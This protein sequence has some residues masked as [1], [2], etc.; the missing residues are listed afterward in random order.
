MPY[1]YSDEPVKEAPRAP[2]IKIPEKPKP[3]RTVSILFLLLTIVTIV[4]LYLLA[5]AQTGICAEPIA[6]AVNASMAS[7]PNVNST[8]TFND[9]Y[10]KGKLE[11]RNATL[12]EGYTKCI[13]ETQNTTLVTGYCAA[14]QEFLANGVLLS[15]NTILEIPTSLIKQ[16]CV[17]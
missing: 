15:N 6:K 14:Q 8:A 1:P 7:A 10:I 9:G 11:S 16:V 12:L 4:S 3:D 5:T 17:K 2:P 13:A